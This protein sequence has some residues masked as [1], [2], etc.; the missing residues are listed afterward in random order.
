MVREYFSGEQ[1]DALELDVKNGLIVEKLPGMPF[2]TADANTH[3]G[4]AIFIM[5]STARIFSSKTQLPFEVHHSSLFQGKPV[6]AAGEINVAQGKLLVSSNKGGHYAPGNDLNNP[7]FTE[8]ASRGIL[9]KTLKKLSVPIE[10]TMEHQCKLHLT[11]SLK[12]PKT[13]SR[14]MKFLMIGMNCND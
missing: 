5:D 12:M 7:L 13:G 8:L 2:N 3:W 14:E 1:L 10:K 4:Y 11:R 9:P 6:A